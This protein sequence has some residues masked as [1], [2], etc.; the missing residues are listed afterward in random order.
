M[1]L[2]CSEVLSAYAVS[3]APACAYIASADA[4]AVMFAP[5]QKFITFK[6][7]QGIRSVQ[8]HTPLKAGGAPDAEASA[9]AVRKLE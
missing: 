6:G 2:Y 5:M 8:K 9:T 1:Y 3:D 4:S 7:G